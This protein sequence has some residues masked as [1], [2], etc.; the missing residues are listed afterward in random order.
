MDE[1]LDR[2]IESVSENIEVVSNLEEQHDNL[3]QSRHELTSDGSLVSGDELAAEFEKFLAE[4]DQKNT[5][6]A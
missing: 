1:D 4:Q 2:Q 5:D 6:E 3:M